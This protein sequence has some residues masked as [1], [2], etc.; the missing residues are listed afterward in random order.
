MNAGLVPNHE[1]IEEE[2][3]DHD[4]ELHSG[5]EDVEVLPWLLLLD[6]REESLE[7]YVVPQ[8]DVD[9]IEE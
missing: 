4:Y 1:G 9:Q 7:E 6:Q 3:V 2:Q 8:Q 5:N